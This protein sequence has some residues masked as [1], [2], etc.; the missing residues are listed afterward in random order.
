MDKLMF[1]ELMNPATPLFKIRM[2]KFNKEETKITI[3]ASVLVLE[4]N[5][6]RY[7]YQTTSAVVP[8][9]SNSFLIQVLIAATQLI[10]VWFSSC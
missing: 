8:Q 6:L 2:D 9:R 5:I 4:E 10:W 3:M 7:F 1:S